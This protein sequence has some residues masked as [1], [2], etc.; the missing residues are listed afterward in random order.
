LSTSSIDLSQVAFA[1]NHA[2]ALL[3]EQPA[4]PEV[5]RRHFAEA[6]SPVVAGE[7]VGTAVHYRWA[8]R[9]LGS[10]LD[11]APTEE[12]VLAARAEASLEMYARRLIVAA[13]TSHLLLDEGFPHPNLGYSTAEME[14]MLRIRIGRMLRIE[15]LVQELIVRHGT[16]PEVVAGFDAALADAQERGYVALKSIACYRTGLAIERVADDE[17]ARVFPALRA[18]AE[19]AGSVRLASKPAIDF[20]VWRAARFA[21]DHGLPFQFHT[22]YGDPDLDLRLANPLHLRPLFEDASLQEVPIVLLHAS[23]PYT[24]EAA[25]LAA[26]YPNAYMDIAF[27][28]PPLDRVE[29]NHILHIALGV[30]PASKIMCSSDGVGIP[31]HYWLGAV[32]ARLCLGQVLGR[33]VE[34]DEIDRRQAEEMGRLLLQGNALRVYRL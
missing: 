1:D 11:V 15:T 5:F 14:A 13:G 4:T 22:G 20:F 25:Y 34:D 32:R 16:W 27:S 24:A 26:V 23:Y 31:E 2:H 9:Q 8:L 19:R 6:H 30:A 3:R 10:L 18:E 28:L 33:L 7:H 12:A 29:L 17:A 21:A